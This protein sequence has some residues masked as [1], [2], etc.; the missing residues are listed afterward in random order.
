MKIYKNILNSSPIEIVTL[1][2]GK[3]GAYNGAAGKGGNI[4]YYTWSDVD[5]N[6]TLCWT[7][8]SSKGKDG[9]K[10]NKKGTDFS[11]KTLSC[12]KRSGL[13]DSTKI[14]QT[15]LSIAKSIGG[16][17]SSG[18]GGGASLISNGGDGGTDG[19]GTTVRRGRRGYA[20]AGGGGGGDYPTFRAG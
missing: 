1:F 9:G 17:G 2:G 6:S 19:H 15:Y 16:A 20:G 5:N 10:K 12:T 8:Y 7:L 4:E 13:T 14:N 3:G 11:E 18:G